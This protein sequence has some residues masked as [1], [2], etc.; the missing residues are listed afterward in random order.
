MSTGS[1]GS[2]A[3]YPVPDQAF[4]ALEHARNRILKANQTQEGMIQLWKN[5]YL[6]FYWLNP[7]GG[8]QYTTAQMQAVINDMP[9]STCRDIMADSAKFVEFVDSAKP[10]ALEEKWKSPAF[11]MT[12]D[13]ITITV[14][15][16]K[17]AWQP[18]PEAVTDGDTIN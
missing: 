18:Q 6:D 3:G 1:T 15:E 9:A 12:D 5:A 2:T 7:N 4:N 13:G 10:G 8:S 14:G 11:E 16:L 17:P